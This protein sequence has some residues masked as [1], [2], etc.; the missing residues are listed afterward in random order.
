MKWEKHKDNVP[1]DSKNGDT[2]PNKRVNFG[3]GRCISKLAYSGC[4]L[5]MCNI[6]DDVHVKGS[7]Y[8][9]TVM[10]SF[11]VKGNGSIG[12]EMD[13]KTYIVRQYA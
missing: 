12:L 4:K 2:K 8:K 9:N 10:M 7:M 13:Q 1:A 5:R 3:L 6:V 11:Q